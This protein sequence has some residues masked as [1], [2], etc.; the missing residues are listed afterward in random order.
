MHFASEP[1]S[2]PPSSIF[3]IF[4]SLSISL[5]PLNTFYGFHTEL[6]SVNSLF[7]LSY[8]LY[9]LRFSN[10]FE[11]S[12]EPHFRAPFRKKGNK[13]LSGALFSTILDC[14]RNLIHPLLRS[15]EMHNQIPKPKPQTPSTHTHTHAHVQPRSAA[16]VLVSS[17][18][19]VYNIRST[20][21]NPRPKLVKLNEYT[22]YSISIIYL[23]CMYDKEHMVMFY[24]FIYYFL[25]NPFNSMHICYT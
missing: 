23:Y 16:W 18:Y 4:Q 1:L 10:T 15:I 25:L 20:V 9:Y 5:S 3:A 13:T 6:L 7:Y 2:T 8:F 17:R 12:T 11:K 24:V 14:L 22:H 21:T 19:L